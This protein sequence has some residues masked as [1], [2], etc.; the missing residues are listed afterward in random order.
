M[1]LNNTELH[2]SPSLCYGN[3][4]GLHSAALPR[5]INS[6]QLGSEPPKDFTAQ[7]VDT[8]TTHAG[9]TVDMDN[10]GGKM[11]IEHDTIILAEK[12]LPHTTPESAATSRT[13]EKP[14]R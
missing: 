6:R 3:G 12:G 7:C 8:V 5:C 10:Q 11:F 14:P 1:E 13:F 4:T 2:N 9:R